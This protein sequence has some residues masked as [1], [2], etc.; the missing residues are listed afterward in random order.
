MAV[1][2]MCVQ[3]SPRDSSSWDAPCLG[4]L[5]KDF[6]GFAVIEIG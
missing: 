6:W 1:Q 4:E 3:S 2:S 5:Q